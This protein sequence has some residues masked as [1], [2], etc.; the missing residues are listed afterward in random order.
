MSCRRTGHECCVVDESGLKFNSIQFNSIRLQ[1]GRCALVTSFSLFKFMMM[2]SAV[3]YCSVQMLFL[4]TNTLGDTE[5][6][7]EDMV[8]ITILALLMGRTGP[9]TKLGSCCLPPPLPLSLIPT[10]LHTMHTPTLTFHIR[11]RFPGWQNAIFA[12][13]L[14][15]MHFNPR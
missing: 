14:R 11:R 3:Q 5:Q 2:Y 12:K 1:E 13:I 10:P 6:M 15:G 9:L 8:L 7:Y 4:I